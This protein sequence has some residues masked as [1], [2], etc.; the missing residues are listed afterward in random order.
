M[1]WQRKGLSLMEVVIGSFLLFWII[2]TSFSFFSQIV[3]SGKKIELRD[4]ANHIAESDLGAQVSK[5]LVTWDPVPVA[6]QEQTVIDGVTYIR[7]VERRTVNG[8]EP[9]KLQEVLV[10]VHW[11]AFGRESEV[12]R[13]VL[14]SQSEL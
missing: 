13:K 7:K 4:I 5:G 8:Y 10:V 14:V 9:A 11:T 6:V 12:V 3:S 2:I 1:S